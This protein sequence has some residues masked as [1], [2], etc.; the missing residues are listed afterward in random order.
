MLKLPI[1][2]RNKLFGPPAPSTGRLDSLRKAQA[3][4]E[5]SKSKPSA[6]KEP[7]LA[8][9]ATEGMHILHLAKHF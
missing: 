7:S 3:A 9:A 2:I 1:S 5:A 8:A 6:K 4:Q